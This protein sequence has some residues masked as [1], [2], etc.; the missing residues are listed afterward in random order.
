[1][2]LDI[3]SPLLARV[4]EFQSFFPSSDAFADSKFQ[5]LRASFKGAINASQT[6]LETARTF[7]S[8][9][10]NFSKNKAVFAGDFLSA[11]M[12]K[13]AWLEG[14]TVATML[15]RGLW[16]DVPWQATDDPA[17]IILA[18][19]GVMLNVALTTLSAVPVVGTIAGGIV[20]AGKLLNQLYQARAANAAAPLQLPWQEYSRDTDEDV[21][22]VLLEQRPKSVDWQ[23]IFSPPF[24]AKPW[25]VG[26]RVQGEGR[27]RHT[28]GLVWGPTTTPSS[29]ELAWRDGAFGCIPGTFRVAGQ[30]QTTDWSGQEVGELRREY[31][32][33]KHT[34]TPR[35]RP[36][37]WRGRFLA[38]G[39]YYPALAQTGGG[40][41]QW[42]MRAGSPDMFK[43]DALQLESLWDDYWGAFWDSAWDIFPKAGQVLPADILPVPGLREPETQRLLS[44]LLMPYV[45]VRRA[46]EQ[47]WTMGVPFAPAPEPFAFVHPGIFEE[48]PVPKNLR[49]PCAWVE[50]FFERKGDWPYK[51]P[52]GALPRQHPDF[53][54]TL[55]AG[56][57][58][59]AFNGTP[60]P[61]W[62]C[63]PYPTAEQAAASYSTPME[64]IIR[65]ALRRLRELQLA[66]LKQTLVCAYVRPVAVGELPAYRAFAEDAELRQ[67][68]LDLRERLLGDPARFSVALADVDVIDPP[69]AEKL[70]KSGV[71]NTW[72]DKPNK[73][74]VAPA[75]NDETPIPEAPPVEGGVAWA[76]LV[77]VGPPSPPGTPLTTPI[78][79]GT[80]LVA[81]AGLVYALSR[82]RPVTLDKPQELPW[83]SSS[84]R[85]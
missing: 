53:R 55:Y 34:F 81:G 47:T 29:R 11:W 64:T 2:R 84:T 25:R 5:A 68:C 50:E 70:R 36:F 22:R 15:P 7:Q 82:R 19:E 69:F 23:G 52:K 8:A 85:A 10:Q 72:R 63:I 79:V 40:V 3:N 54:A 26:A 80:A 14:K 83:R 76:D 38:C 43:V 62:A 60:G 65:P 61:G 17:K 37:Y 58:S 33:P 42:V 49:N 48:G 71:T 12:P 24:E 66:C 4:G 20:A 13:I 21:V 56:G 45:C 28:T 75:D 35:E 18:I 30:T 41:W 32:M 46:G 1:M 27:D 16:A 39:D 77:L 73:F 31:L 59:P 6:V 44:H 78:L 67:R 9:L 57:M 74:A 51:G